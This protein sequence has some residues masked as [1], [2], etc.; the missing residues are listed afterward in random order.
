MQIDIV[1]V[2]AQIF[3]FALLVWLLNKFLYK[4]IVNVISARENAVRERLEKAEQLQEEARRQLAAYT[5][6]RAEL[7]S[8]REQWLKE[9][10]EE[11][12]RVREN[13]LEQAAADAEA[14]RRRLMQQLET[15]KRE[16]AEAFQE[17]VIRAAGGVARRLLRDMT[18]GD[19]GDGVI[20]ALER[21]LQDRPELLARAKPPV[22]VRLSFGPTASQAARVRALVARALGRELADDDVIV[23]HDDSLILGVEVHYDGTL[24][25]WNARD[26][27]AAWEEDAARLA[28][29]AGRDGGEGHP[30]RS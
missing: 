15:E 3:N 26:Y 4:P 24:L 16:L 29:G 30:V 5:A 11:A 1:T 20:A 7:E 6:Q 19:A 22:T 21:R 17:S 2:V 23:E 10:R 9:A 28:A 14:E 12:R 25:A 8:T 27:V 13:L 18:G